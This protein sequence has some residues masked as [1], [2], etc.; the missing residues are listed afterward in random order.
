VRGLAKGGAEE[1]VEVE[2]GEAGLAGSVL[3]QDAGGVLG[4]EEVARAAEA[5]KGVVVVEER[6][7]STWERFSILV[8]TMIGAC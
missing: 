7:G 8:N 4:G 3:E 6:V 2:V 5:A 1:A